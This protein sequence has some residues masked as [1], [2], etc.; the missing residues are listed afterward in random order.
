MR[1]HLE[2]CVFLLDS[3]AKV[4]MINKFGETALHKACTGASL[5]LL[6][7]FIS[8]GADPTIQSAHG[9]PRDLLAQSRSDEAVVGDMRR[10]LAEYEA[11]YVPK[12]VNLL[13]R[14]EGEGNGNEPV[15]QL[16]DAFQRA[17]MVTGS[18]SS[19]LMRDGATPR[20]GS[21]GPTDPPA[22]A[23]GVPRI[24]VKGTA[25]IGSAL[26]HSAPVAPLH[27]SA[28][29]SPLLGHRKSLDGIDES[30]F[31]SPEPRPKSGR[32]SPRFHATARRTR[33][34]SSAEGEG[35][36]LS[37]S[38]QVS[39]LLRQPSAEKDLDAGTAANAGLIFTPDATFR[40]ETSGFG[41]LD[42]MHLN[43]V[44][45]LYRRSL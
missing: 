17:S 20:R 10:V 11:E 33:A 16:S 7:L 45:A 21:V 12:P 39:R 8:V 37:N 4:D 19:D 5:E 31:L 9:L 42:D 22:A 15:A 27:V 28:P 26:T 2:M 13:A 38:P 34:V 41:R 3:G 36:I 32:A 25:A 43:R 35:V 29:N 14:G 18:S 6:R 44:P 23:A 40:Q 1:K 30:A 24:S